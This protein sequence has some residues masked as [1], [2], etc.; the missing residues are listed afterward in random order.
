MVKRLTRNDVKCLET[1]LFIND[2]STGDCLMLH[3]TIGG[4][5]G[6]GV[7]SEGDLIQAHEL[8][9]AFWIISCKWATNA[10]VKKLNVGSI[11]GVLD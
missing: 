1:A 11:E 10:I 2:L 9:C 6:V 8:N 4:G 7:L 3:E 5:A